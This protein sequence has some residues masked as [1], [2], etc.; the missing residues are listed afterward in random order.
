MSDIG[1]TANI[2][3]SQPEDVTSLQTAYDQWRLDTLPPRWQESS[4]F[5]DWL[6]IAGDWNGY[7]EHDLSA[8]WKLT[9]ISAPG[10][11]A[12][13]DSYNWY[14]NVIH[15]ATTGGNTPPGVH[16]FAFV[17]GRTYANQWGGVSINVDNS[18]TVPYYSG[19]SLGPTN[20]ISF[21]DGHYHSFRVLDPGHIVA[22]LR[23]AVLKTSAAPI[24][25]SRS[26]QTPDTP[27]PD[28][29]IVISIALSQP[30]V[31]EE[32]MVNRHFYYITLG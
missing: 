9:R 6:V 2:A 14:T 16:S 17:A 19:G 22:N 25:V 23:V 21:G 10:I 20:T 7:N 3:V 32:R 11:P 30:K 24:T 18:T 31:T 15:V 27:G 1:E 12:T 29:P 4:S 13:P 5:T 28:D 8:P 26:G